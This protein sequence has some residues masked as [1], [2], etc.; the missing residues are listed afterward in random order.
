VEI[1]TFNRS[2]NRRTYGLVSPAAEQDAKSLGSNLVFSR[3]PQRHVK[4]Q[5][6]GFRREPRIGDNFGGALRG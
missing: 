6:N 1:P 3:P 4:H 2:P 5:A